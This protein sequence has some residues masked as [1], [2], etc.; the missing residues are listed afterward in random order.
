MN[1]IAVNFADDLAH[2]QAA[3]E[4]RVELR[5][6]AAQKEREKLPFYVAQEPIVGYGGRVWLLVSTECNDANG[7]WHEP[8]ED[9][10]LKT[11][12]E[13]CKKLCM[14]GGSDNAITANG[15]CYVRFEFSATRYFLNATESTDW[16]QIKE[17]LKGLLGEPSKRLPEEQ[18]EPF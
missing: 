16:E 14:W 12:H 4:H 9:P 2:L 17:Q 5:R 10:Q 15:G 1:A 7:S 6:V 11:A 8:V 18:H 13:A 3:F